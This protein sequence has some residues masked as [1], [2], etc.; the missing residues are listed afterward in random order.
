MQDNLAGQEEQTYLVALGWLG[1]IP[2][3]PVSTG[4][5]GWA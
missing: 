2:V 4:E 5:K 3:E 1:W